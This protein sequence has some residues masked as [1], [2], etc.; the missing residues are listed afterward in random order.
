MAVSLLASGDD[1]VPTLPLLLLLLLLLL[2]PVLVVVVA[3]LAP[4]CRGAVIANVDVVG[5]WELLFL[6]LA[7]S[8]P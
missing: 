6:L 8:A 2:L 3:P 4:L 7:V 5:S 1:D